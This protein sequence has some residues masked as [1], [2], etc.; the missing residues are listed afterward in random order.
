MISLRLTGMIWKPVFDSVYSTDELGD[1][2]FRVGA[3]AI[4]GCCTLLILSAFAGVKYY[5]SNVNRE[6]SAPVQQQLSFLAGLRL[7]MTNRVGYLPLS[8]CTASN[9]RC[10][11][12]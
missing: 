8:N 5:Y 9:S 3:T 12:M 6:F 7:T 11:R 4:G 1:N 10:R 2:R